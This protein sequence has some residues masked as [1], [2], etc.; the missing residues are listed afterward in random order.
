MGYCELV[1]AIKFMLLLLMIK[2]V[3]TLLHSNKVFVNVGLSS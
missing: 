1:G 3:S 2:F